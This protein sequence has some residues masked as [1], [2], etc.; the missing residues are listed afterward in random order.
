MSIDEIRARAAK[1]VGTV[2]NGRWWIERLLDVGGM[3]AVYVAMHRNGRKAAIKLL[4]PQ[5][6]KNSEVAMRFAREGYV[7]NK[8]NHPGA[9]AIMDDDVTE[10]GAPYLVMELLEGESMSDRLAK[11]G[12]RLGVGETL[13]I[14]GQVLEV[15]ERAHVAG[16]VHRDIKPANIFITSAGFAKLLDFG[17]ARVRDGTGS[18]LPTAQG[19]V[20]GTAGYMAPEQAKGKTDEVDARSD[21]FS[22]GAVIFRALSGRH[23]HEEKTAFDMT[24]A[25][26]TKPAPALRTV[27]PPASPSLSFAVDRA[28]AFDRRARWSTA[29]EMFDALKL[30]FH[31]VR[32]ASQARMTA[33]TLPAV[34]APTGTVDISLSQEPSLVIDITFGEEHEAAAEREAE[35]TKAV[36]D[37]LVATTKRSG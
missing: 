18:V 17:L 11:A 13:A 12:G 35:R 21:L 10:D 14:A 2:L 25:A 8:I 30:A 3:G 4:H 36:Q 15:L 28:L 27:F 32:S 23:I 26:M 1:R 24:M 20:M 7:A 9:L 29:R 19:I 34:T 5:F 37:S 22:V 31:D 16:I 6:A 33:V